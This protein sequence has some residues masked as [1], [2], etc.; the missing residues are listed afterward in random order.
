MSVRIAC[1]ENDGAG[2]C[3][4]Y[5]NNCLPLKIREDVDCRDEEVEWRR[6]A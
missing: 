1:A 4:D 2:D 5:C 6:Q 3:T